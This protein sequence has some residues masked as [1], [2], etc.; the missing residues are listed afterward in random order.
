MMRLLLISGVYICASYIS[1]QHWD[2][3][4]VAY[5]THEIPFW[6][7]AGVVFVLGP[8]NNIGFLGE[9]SI[10]VSFLVMWLVSTALL[11]LFLLLACLHRRPNYRRFGWVMI[12]ILW[13]LSGGQFYGFMLYG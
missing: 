1:W 13:L 8:L 11:L 5:Q 6:A 3:L 4:L 12:G 9:S 7:L 2:L 10:A